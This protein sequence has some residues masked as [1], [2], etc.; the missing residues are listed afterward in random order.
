MSG[1]QPRTLT[2]EELA[3]YA[4]LEIGGKNGLPAE[5]QKELLQRFAEI[6]DTPPAPK[7]PDP[8]QLELFPN[9]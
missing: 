1:I 9:P 5:W 4:E 2:N 6:C 3:K 8:R 7:Q